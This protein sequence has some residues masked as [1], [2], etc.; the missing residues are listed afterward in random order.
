MTKLPDRPYL[1]TIEEV[2]SEYARS[3]TS[4]LDE[5]LPSDCDELVFCGGTGDYLRN[6]MH[7]NGVLDCKC[8][9]INSYFSYQSY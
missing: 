5:N 4:W 3:L 8:D 9:T 6:E 1:A 2:Q 7:C